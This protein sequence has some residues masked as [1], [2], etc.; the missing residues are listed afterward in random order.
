MS[1]LIE[2]IFDRTFAS[3]QEITDEL[4]EFYKKNPDELDLIIEEEEFHAGFLY[5]FFWL[6]LIVTIIPRT[7]QALFN[8]HISEFVKIVILDL[9]SEVGIAIFGGTLVAYFIE[10]LQKKQFEKNKEFRRKVKQRIQES[11]ASN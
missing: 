4:V 2:K 6:G 8:D 3:D 11:S 10:F 7:I 9:I 5:F 1:S